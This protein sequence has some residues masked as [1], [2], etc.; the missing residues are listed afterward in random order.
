MQ[1]FISQAFAVHM[2][3]RDVKYRRISFTHWQFVVIE[4]VLGL[5]IMPMRWTEIVH[6]HASYV[7]NHLLQTALWKLLVVAGSSDIAGWY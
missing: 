5:T 7:H 4:L 3:Y 2:Y 6:T 1:R